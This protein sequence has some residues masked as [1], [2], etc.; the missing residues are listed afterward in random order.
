MTETT[1][2]AGMRERWAGNDRARAEAAFNA[3][4]PTAPERP[5]AVQEAYEAKARGDRLFQLELPIQS[6]A[7]FAGNGLAQTYW[8]HHGQ[9]GQIL[10]QVEAYGWRLEH[11]STVFAPAS[12][13]HMGVARG[14]D[15][16]TQGVLVGVYLFRD[17]PTVPA[18][19]AQ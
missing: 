16:F 2:A 18:A 15:A 1:E 12:T 4:F 17:D 7:G 3:Q 10:S 9:P 5:T 6:T 14:A 13:V 8:R 19:A 11:V